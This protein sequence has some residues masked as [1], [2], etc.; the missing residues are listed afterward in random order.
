M[1]RKETGEERRGRDRGGSM[2]KDWGGRKE[3]FKTRV[4]NKKKKRTK[5]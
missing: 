5:S 4:K 3:M 1:K 2:E